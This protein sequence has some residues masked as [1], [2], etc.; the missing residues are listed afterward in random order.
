MND[1]HRI[2][3]IADLLTKIKGKISLPLLNLAFRF[4]FGTGW[5]SPTFLRFWF[6][7]DRGSG[8]SRYGFDDRFIALWI[9]FEPQIRNLIGLLKFVTKTTDQ[10]IL[11]RFDEDFS[12]EEVRTRDPHIENSGT[13][14]FI[15]KLFTIQ[16]W[17]FFTPT[18][19][20]KGTIATQP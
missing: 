10:I 14:D 20:K 3:L 11:G 15:D 4:V 16:I 1:S 18:H 13:V 6:G 17:H 9:F 5:S 7:I 2:T 8:S 19:Y 12:S